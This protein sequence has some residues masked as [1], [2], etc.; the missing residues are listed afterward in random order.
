MANFFS[1]N[2]GNLTDA[3]AYGYS[4]TGAEIMNNTTGTMLLTSGLYSANVFSD[5]SP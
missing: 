5:G 1:L 2:D 3:S 4:L